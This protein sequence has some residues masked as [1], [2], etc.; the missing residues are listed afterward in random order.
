MT[1]KGENPIKGTMRRLLAGRLGLS[2]TGDPLSHSAMS[3]ESPSPETGKLECLITVLHLSVG[4][5][6]LQTCPSIFG[7]P[8]GSWLP[9]HQRKF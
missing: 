1:G 9:W 6:A 4:E 2:P 5:G 7:C 3:L 8:G